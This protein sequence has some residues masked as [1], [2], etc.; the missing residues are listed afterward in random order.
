MTLTLFCKRKGFAGMDMFKA[1]E[2]E[3]YVE[4]TE[5]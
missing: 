5:G 2:V 4:A 1:R 3:D